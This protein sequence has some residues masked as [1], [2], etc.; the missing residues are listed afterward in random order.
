MHIF[1]NQV[2]PFFPVQ[3]R[4]GLQLQVIGGMEKPGQRAQANALSWWN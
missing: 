1:L 3:A 4:N 2:I